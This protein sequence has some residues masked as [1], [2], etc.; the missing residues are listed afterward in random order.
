MSEAIPPLPQY[1]FMEWCLVKH[2]DS[3]TFTFNFSGSTRL[4]QVTFYGDNKLVWT[5]ME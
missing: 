2:G 1:S 5:G 4:L 3:F